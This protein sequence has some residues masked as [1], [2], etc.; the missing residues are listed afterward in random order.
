[1]FFYLYSK[2]T[3]FSCSHH[4]T[5]ICAFYS[6]KKLE[7]DC[8]TFLLF[9]VLQLKNLSVVTSFT[10]LPQAL[11][12]LICCPLSLL[13]GDNMVK[14]ACTSTKIHLLAGLTL[15]LFLNFALQEKRNRTFKIRVEKK[16]KL[17]I[18][19]TMRCSCQFCLQYSQAISC[20]SRQKQEVDQ[21]NFL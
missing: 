3:W 16:K 9:F 2:S 1:M 21:S 4:W 10:T 15:F 14:H 19:L 18:N 11:A 8:V 20:Y 6:L 13:Y 5:V 17:N 7:I 12:E